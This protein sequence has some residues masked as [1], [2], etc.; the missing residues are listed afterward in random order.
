MHV[1]TARKMRDIRV[2]AGGEIVDNHHPMTIS[3][4]PVAQVR[5]DET[6]TSSNNDPAASRQRRARCV[7]ER[8]TP[9]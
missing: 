9:S 1:V 7:H 8:P 3:E 4:E 2:P 5:P 6:G